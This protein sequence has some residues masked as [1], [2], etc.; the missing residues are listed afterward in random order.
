M[1]AWIH[2]TDFT[3][4]LAASETACVPSATFLPEECRGSGGV[5][6]QV[7]VTVLR[8]HAPVGGFDLREPILDEVW[9]VLSDAAARTLPLRSAAAAGRPRRPVVPGSGFPIIPYPTSF[10]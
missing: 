5:S 6:A 8:I 1:L 7:G 2:P 4:D 9:G 3:L 10:R